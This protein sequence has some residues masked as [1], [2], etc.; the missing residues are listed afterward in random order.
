MGFWNRVFGKKSQEASSQ[1]GTIG[2]AP[3]PARTTT[4]SRTDY[5]HLK[6]VLDNFGGTGLSGDDVMNIVANVVGKDARKTAEADGSFETSGKNIQN[7]I[8]SDNDCPC[9]D[10]KVLVLGKTAYLYISPEVVKFRAD[11][12]TMADLRMK[13][14]RVNSPGGELGAIAGA[15]PKYLCEMGARRRGLNLSVALADGVAAARTGFA[16]LRPTP[17]A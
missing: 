11:C 10:Q 8:C 12:L 1:R 6:G 17:R 14:L 16:P 7:I 4:E 13:V 2:A 9:S 15:M 5:Q 3:A